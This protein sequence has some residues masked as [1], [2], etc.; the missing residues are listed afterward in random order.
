MTTPSDTVRPVEIDARAGTDFG[1]AGA[2]AFRRDGLLVLRGLL[3]AAELEALRAD[4]ARLIDRIDPDG[5]ATADPATGIGAGDVHWRRHDDADVPFRIEYV[6]D[7]SLACRRLL[8][9]PYVLASLERLLGDALVPTWD[10]MV[11]KRA[12]RGASIPWHR[13]QRRGTI[14]VDEIAGVN[15]DFYLDA[16]DRTTCLRGVPGSHRWTEDEVRRYTSAE[17]REDFDAL[18]ATL[19]PMAAGDVLLHDAFVLHGSPASATELRRV[20]YLEYRAAGSEARHGPHD[21]G[22]SRIKRELLGR[23]VAARKGD[24]DAV[25]A[26]VGDGAF[27]VPH[28]AHWR[29]DAGFLAGDDVRA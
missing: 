26:G 18:P 10:S 1:D 8:A 17:G 28:E 4:T 29:A 14:P 9:H 16:A 2:Q 3:G 11:F 23:C 25:G 20:V 19:L 15:V 7:K 24:G 5:A 13:D 27:R 6:V 21:A 22:Y 12:G